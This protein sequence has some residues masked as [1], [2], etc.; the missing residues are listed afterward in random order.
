VT[1]PPDLP[2]VT[3]RFVDANGLRFHV[4]EAGEGPPL[5][6]LHGWPQHWWMWRHA[7]PDLSRRYRVIA[8][9]LRG[10]GWTDSPEHGPWDKETLA[11]DVLALLDAL[12]LDR[13]RLI[14]HDWGGWTSL[15]LAMRAPERLERVLAFSIPPPWGHSF[16]P[17]PLLGIGHIP[18]VSLSRRTVPGITRFLLDAGSGGRLT[19]D[20]I[21][22]YLERLRRPEGRRASV[23]YYRS[24]L[25]GELPAIVAGRYRGRT[26][27]VPVR[28][29]GGAQDVV[30]R[31]SP[32]V[33]LVDGVRHFLPEERP[34]LVL[35]HAASF[36]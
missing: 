2:G 33:E 1:E 14:G 32:G 13:V 17:R 9:D 31:W 22:V 4:A 29:V 34:E 18:F 8:P 15:L 36:L 24:M 11:D 25:F 21:E 12:G 16:D 10:L 30:V 26:P 28:I 23:G 20:E 3:H 6:L 5:V 7:I 27:H 19:E 35:D